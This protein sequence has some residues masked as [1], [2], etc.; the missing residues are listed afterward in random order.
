MKQKPSYW[1]NS[2][3]HALALAVALHVEGP[4]S[5]THAAARLDVATSTAHRLLSMLVYRDFAI[6]DE[7]RIY[8][9]GPMLS[10][11]PI[12]TENSAHLRDVALPHLRRLANSVGESAFLMIL[13]GAYSRF[14]ASAEASKPNKIAN[15][16]GMIFPA[17]AT[18]AGLAM[19]AELSP[20]QLEKLYSPSS[21]VHLQ[22]QLP[23][24]SAMSA[25]LHL[26]RERGYALAA[27]Q[28]EP[29]V[30][31]VGCVLRWPGSQLHCGLSVAAPSSRF[32]DLNL[33]G[34]VRA[35]SRAARAIEKDLTKHS[36]HLAS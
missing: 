3:D 16:D 32:Q 7:H 24:V 11:G 23:S 35:L 29:G 14:L 12:E 26:I 10:L 13:T 17:H 20:A 9:A 1:I 21:L 8:H 19:L 28:A 18:S 27:E 36:T 2:V 6:Q 4:M 31:A 22:G 5:V 25:Q 15:R 33:D 34:T 30:T